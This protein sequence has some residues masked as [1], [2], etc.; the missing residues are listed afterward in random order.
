MTLYE[1]FLR[2]N[3][4]VADEL[5][6]MGEFYLANTL[7][8]ITH[9]VSSTM[10]DNECPIC[11]KKITDKEELEYVHSIGMCLGCDSIKEDIKPR[12]EQE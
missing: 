1:D 4:K 7:L 9:E 6:K 8:E 5:Q 10:L 3:Y 2:T 12:E 11:K